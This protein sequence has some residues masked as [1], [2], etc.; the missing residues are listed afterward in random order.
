MTAR[1]IL[2]AIMNLNWPLGSYVVYG[3]APMAMVG[4]REAGDIDFFVSKELFEV[5]QKDGWKQITKSPTDKPLTSGDFEAHDNWNFSHY[6]P[7]LEHLIAT[8]DI[9][10]GIPF[11]NIHEVRKWKAG[12]GRPKDHTD[13]VLIDAYLKAHPRK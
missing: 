2:G 9:I 10:E 3:S 4:L 7:T 12:S 5:L 1:Q 6:K 11:A 13:I 8:A